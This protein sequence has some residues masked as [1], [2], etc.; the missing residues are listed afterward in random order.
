MLPAKGSS[1]LF[2]SG[3]VVNFFHDPYRQR[4]VATWKTTTERG[5]AVGVATSDDGLVW[6]KPTPSA[7]MFAD[8]LDPDATQLYG[9]PVFPY[10]GYY[11]GLPW[12]YNARWPKDRPATD[13]N[14]RVAERTSPNTMDVQ[15]AWSRNLVQWNRTPAR[16]SFIP[17]GA[18][19]EFD[20]GM[21]YTARSPVLMGDKLYF[22]YGGF[23]GPHNAPAGANR[24]AIGLGMLRLD[25]FCS[26]RAGTSVGHF[27]SRPEQFENPV[28]SINARTDADGVIEAE[29][30]DGS[31]KA[32]V[33]FSRADCISFRGDDVRHRLCWK[34]S[35]FAP[36]QIGVEKR[37]RF[38]LRDADIYSYATHALISPSNP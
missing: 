8:D 6:N 22:Y 7:V 36:E 24:A 35:T 25:G 10:Q 26:M 28:V 37:L 15:L 3:D 21:I 13:D 31:G 30:I 38:F 14:L 32:L 4:Y 1:G 17:R 5:R 23:N 27:I 12:V 2:P 19:G 18:A 34:N 29:I 11:I 16:S 20:S 9:M 33:G